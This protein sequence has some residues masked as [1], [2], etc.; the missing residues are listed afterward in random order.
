MSV[1]RGSLP[2]LETAGVVEDAD[3][4]GE[5]NRSVC[6]RVDSSDPKPL[7]VDI[8]KGIFF[9]SLMNKKRNYFVPS[10]KNYFGSIKVDKLK[11]DS[12]CNTMLL[13]LTKFEDLCT[14]FPQASH[15]YGVGYGNGVSGKSLAVSIYCRATLGNF[16]IR[17]ANDLFHKEIKS[18]RLRFSLCSDDIRD[19]LE[20]EEYCRLFTED[21][22]KKLRDVNNGSITF[23]RR[24]HGLLGQAI[25]SNMESIKHARCELC[26]DTSDFILPSSF[27]E[28][29]TTIGHIKSQLETSL[30]ADFDYWE[31]DDVEFEDEEWDADL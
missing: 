13:P 17:I 26:V 16:S 25:L 15:R 24:H 7:L 8:P 20:S 28:L 9:I 12:G 29:E 19:I 18:T 14:A 10:T 21:S 22:L 27:P 4:V 30:P 6:P 11:C 3:G 31:D 23:H 5:T 2:V 1:K